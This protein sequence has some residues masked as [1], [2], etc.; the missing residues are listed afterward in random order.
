MH[1]MKANGMTGVVYTCTC[2]LMQFIYSLLFVLLLAT[3]PQ[4]YQRFGRG[5]SYEGYKKCTGKFTCSTTS[6]PGGRVIVATMV[7]WL[8]GLCVVGNCDQLNLQDG[9]FVFGRRAFWLLWHRYVRFEVAVLFSSD[10]RVGSGRKLWRRRLVWS[11]RNTTPNL[12]MIFTPTRKS[13]RRWQ[14]CQRRSFEIKLLGTVLTVVLHWF[15]MS[16]VCSV[17]GSTFLLLLDSFASDS[18]TDFTSCHICIVLLS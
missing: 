10:F 17:R 2:R 7:L 3:R 18:E 6:Y 13:S 1:H 5:L 15:L 8:R 14:F 9:A 16:R 12:E 11:S 4:T